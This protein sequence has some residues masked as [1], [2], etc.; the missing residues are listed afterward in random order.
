MPETP[1]ADVLLFAGTSCAGKDTILSRL[2]T[3]R[4]ELRKVVT[5]TTRPPRSYEQ[6]GTHYHFLSPEAFEAAVQAGEFIEHARVHDHR[7]GLTYAELVRVRRQGGV[8]VAIMD[9][10]GVR[11]VASK[12]NA[13]RVFVT[14]PTEQW[15]RRMRES[16]PGENLAAR[17]ASARIELLE[18]A[19]YDFVL[20]NPDGGLEEAVQ[21]IVGWYDTAIRP[22]FGL[23]PERRAHVVR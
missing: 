13:V 14:A 22:R 21:Q 9:V 23:G 16:R 5:T 19:D 7:Y 6:D 11:T 15:Q 1:N 4:P 3:L 12:L 20:Q 18:A 10:Q 2:L 17:I 8:P